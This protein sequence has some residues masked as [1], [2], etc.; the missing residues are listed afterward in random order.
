MI[1]TL[2]HGNIGSGNG[3]QDYAYLATTGPV[4]SHLSLGAMAKG[5]VLHPLPALRTLWAKTSRR[6]GEPRAVRAARH[7]LGVA[8]AHGAESSS[9]ANNL[10][11]N[12]L[13]AAP[14]FQS[15]PLYILMPVGTVAVLAALAAPRR[16]IALLLTALVVAQA[17]G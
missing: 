15:L 13:F 10:F 7:R 6:L 12:W 2:V 16:R 3:L 1:I 5:I 14:G 9:L 11:P 17:I 8:A 4:P